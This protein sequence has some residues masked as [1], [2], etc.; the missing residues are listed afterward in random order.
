MQTSLLRRLS[1]SLCNAVTEQAGGQAMLEWLER[2]N[3]FVVPLDDERRWYRYHH[4]FAEALAHRL[5]QTQ[6]ERVAIVHSRA[7]A[8]YKAQGMPDDAIRH[9]LAAQDLARAVGLL[10]LHAQMA[11]MHGEAATILR[12]L[13]AIPEA[14]IRTSPRL[15]IAAGWAHYIALNAGGRLEWIEPALQDAERSIAER[16][17]LSSLEREQLLAEVYA[18]RATIAIEQGDTTRGIG[19]AEVA[20]DHLPASNLLLRS[21][22]SYSL[23]DAYRAGGDTGAAIQAFAGARALGETSSSLMTALLA[24]FELSEVLIEHGQLQKAAATCRAALSLVERHAERGDHA[25][26]LAGAARIGLAKVLYEWN[27]LDEARAQLEAGIELTRQ[28]GGLGIARHGV[29]ALAFVEQAQG[30]VDRARTLVEEAEQLARASPR[31]DA[32]PRLWP[33][34]VRLWLTQG[35][36][37]AARSWAHQSRYDPHQAPVYPE[38]L[39]YGV[40]ARVY[41]TRPTADRLRQAD[42]LVSSALAVAE[43][44]GRRGHVIELLVLQALALHA[45]ADSEPALAALSRSLALAE[46]EGYMRTFL[47]AGPPLVPLLRM[48]RAHGFAP[49]YIRRLLDACAQEHT[50][51]TVPPWVIP[52]PTLAEP[53]TQRE[54][55]VLRLLVAGLSNADIAS[56]LVITVGTTKRHVLHIY[57]KLDVRS[58]AQAIIKARELGLVE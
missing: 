52:A 20:L 25:V 18:L 36:L 28:P 31:S 47:D 35:N 24:S 34:K 21:S 9:A 26:A 42:A 33:A 48:A 11:I 12:W 32:L 38:E 19:L 16:S 30:H 56:R 5:E 40:L 53:L 8:W 55:E 41:L 58:R 49:V 51:D 10:D 13:D 44:H 2:A 15:C 50:P 23:G 29:L 17:D 45:Q 22:L 6:P 43:A 57:G 4:L 27:E 46:P 39:A 54:Q 7:S 14:Q 3:L 37:P 1:T